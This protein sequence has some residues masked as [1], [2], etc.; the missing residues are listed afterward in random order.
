MSGTTNKALRAAALLHRAVDT[1][2]SLLTPPFCRH[3]RTALWDH[4][5]PF[6]CRKCAADVMWADRHA[7]PAC[8]FPLGSAVPSQA[9]CRECRG[10]RLNLTA[11]ASVVRYAKGARSLVLAFK[12]GGEMEL[13]RALG[14]LM[15]HRLRD[16]D[17]PA[18][19]VVA[20]A[21]S[22]AARS[23][24]RGFDPAV[25]LADRVASEAGLR[26]DTR[27][28][29]RMRDTKPQSTLLREERA[30]NMAHAFRAN[31]SLDGA[32]VLLVDDVMTT[33]ATLADCARACRDAG[34]RRVYALVFAR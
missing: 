4:D 28:L 33:G 31:R 32:T 20:A 16:A 2:F 25:L 7:C 8:G 29:V 3:C 10:K 21:A 22:H 14:S 6:L 15:A 27:L 13:A 24:R 12:F 1:A 34:A 17:F 26:A 5:Q 18:P 23:R 11:A 30:R 9:D 19:D